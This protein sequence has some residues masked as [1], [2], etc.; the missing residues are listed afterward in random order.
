MVEDGSRLTERAALIVFVAYLVA[1]VPLLLLWLGDYHWFFGDEW[2]FLAERDGG[3]L[4]DLFRSHG[5]HWVTVPVVIY[6]IMFNVFGLDSYVPYQAVVVVS[7]VALCSLLR[8]VMRRAGVEAW[9]ATVVA[10]GFV[11]FAPGQENILWAFQIAFVIALG[12]G[13]AHMLLADVDG[14]IRGRDGAG[15]A[16]GFIGLMTSGVSLVM[17]P[18]V[19]LVVLL[20]RGWRAALFHS[21]PLAAAY[22]IWY[23]A[24]DPGG[25]DN[26][27]GRAATP[28]ELARFVW[29]GAPAGLQAVGGRLGIGIV[30]AGIAGVGLAY[31]VRSSAGRARVVPPAAMFVG[32]VGFLLGTAQSRWF[33][34]AEVGSQ[35]RYLYT[36]AA[37]TLPLL[38]VGADAVGRRG[39][40][41]RMAI[42]A[43]FVVALVLNLDG[44]GQ[45]RPFGSNYHRAQER[46]VPALAHSDLARSVPPYVR[47]SVWYTVGWLVEMAEDGQWA[48]DAS[49]GPRDESEFVPILM[50]AQLDR[51]PP[52]S[53]AGAVDEEVLTTVAG[54]RLGFDFVGPIPDDVAWFALDSLRVDLLD[55]QGETTGRAWYPQSFGSVIEFALPDLRVRLQPAAP[56][57]QMVLCEVD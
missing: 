34:T 55:D 23:L 38:A 43:P 2:S 25:I 51:D 40:V 26:P 42:L 45:Q 37:L 3:D 14:P 27:T 32:A 13:V 18:V 6:R 36:I 1:G 46:F 24:T 29:S 21:G 50:A 8:I 52:A 5:E 41:W 54:R 7:H 31:V 10:G 9:T 17:T 4:E 57:Q 48:F 11:L 53:C 30:I 15:L 39:P 16:I 47:P 28:S 44:F 56:G 35:S 49:T 19:A 33:V 12:C 20:R 22:V